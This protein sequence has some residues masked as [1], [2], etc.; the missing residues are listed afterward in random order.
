MTH[1]DDPSAPDPSPKWSW[2][3]PMTFDA[4]GICQEPAWLRGMTRAEIDALTYEEWTA[5]QPR[6][7]NSRFV[8]V[9]GDGTCDRPSLSGFEAHQ[10]GACSDAVRYPYDRLLKV[11]LGAVVCRGRLEGG[12]EWWACARCGQVYFRAG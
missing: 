5:L 3:E 2:L 10:C 6:D 12:S 4:D 1:R 9:D 11:R 8:V 7:A